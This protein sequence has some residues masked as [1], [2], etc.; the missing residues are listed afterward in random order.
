MKHGFQ[1]NFGESSGGGGSSECPPCWNLEVH[2]SVSVFSRV[3]GV[4]FARC[5]YLLSR[6]GSAPSYGSSNT[7]NRGTDIDNRNALGA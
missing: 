3:S 7:G 5:S 4:A 2:R 1:I 6:V